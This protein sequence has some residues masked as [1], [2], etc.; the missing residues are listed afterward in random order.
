MN[1]LS[2]WRCNVCETFNDL[3]NSTCIVC[4]FKR[5][6]GKDIDKKEASHNRL[7]QWRCEVCE[8]FNNSNSSKCIVCDF[9]RDI[10][11]SIK[12]VEE[13]KTIIKKCAFEG[14]KSIAV[15]SQQY[16]E[17]HAHTVCP[18]CSAKLKSSG[19]DYCIDCGLDLVEKNT[20]VLRK[21]S[22]AFKI[23]DVGMLS[24][25]VILL[26]SYIFYFN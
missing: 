15:G 23:I 8:S 21:L 11:K 9:E 20:S 13:S 3:N 19:M 5:D 1:Y 16:C 17:Y 2:K 14:C 24:I 22:M 25:L 26:L 12:N 7:H 10:G 18:I 4:D 6:I